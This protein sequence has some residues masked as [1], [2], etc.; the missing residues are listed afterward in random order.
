LL[1]KVLVGEDNFL[2]LVEPEVQGHLLALLLKVAELVEG[3]Q[4]NYLPE[5]RQQGG[6]LELVVVVVVGM[7]R[8]EALVQQVQFLVEEDHPLVEQAEQV[9]LQ[10]V[11]L[12][13]QRVQLQQ[14]IKVPEVKQLT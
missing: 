12:V 3:V 8:P 4:I 9:M 1:V 2:A 5:V 10:V 6:H 14:A 11:Q 7:V 13:L